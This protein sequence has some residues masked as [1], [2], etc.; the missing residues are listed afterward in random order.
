MSSNFAYKLKKGSLEPFLARPVG[1]E[2]TLTVLETVILDFED[3]CA[4]LY[5]KGALTAAAITPHY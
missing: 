1:L 2:P 5:T 4:C 3:R